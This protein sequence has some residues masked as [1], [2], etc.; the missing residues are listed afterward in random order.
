MLWQAQELIEIIL[1]TN[2][3]PAPPPASIAAHLTTSLGRAHELGAS[4]VSTGID[5]APCA[6]AH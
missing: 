4:A 5:I 2:Q 6:C 1:P 3:I